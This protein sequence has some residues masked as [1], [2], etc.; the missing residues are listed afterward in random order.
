MEKNRQI[1][2]KRTPEEP[3][4]LQ[5]MKLKK[6]DMTERLTHHTHIKY[7]ENIQVTHRKTGKEN[8]RTR[9]IGK[10]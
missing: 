5:S 3:G 2:C 1:L 6:S 8:K 7:F 4:G 10:K 9:E